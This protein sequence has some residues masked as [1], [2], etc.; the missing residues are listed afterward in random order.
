MKPQIQ[1]EFNP[2]PLTTTDEVE[3]ME[4]KR[5]ASVVGHVFHLTHASILDKLIQDVKVN[6]CNGYAI[7]H[8]SQRQHSCLMMDNEDAWIY[9]HD[10]VSEKF[11]LGMVMKKAKS[12]CS[13]LGFTLGQS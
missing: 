7:D 8:P 5:I 12:V 6:L 3:E 11:D 13:A 1:V 10:E 2:G 9:Y 4:R